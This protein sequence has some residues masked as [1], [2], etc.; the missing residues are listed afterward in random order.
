MEKMLRLCKIQPQEALTE[1]L[2][3]NDKSRIC[4]MLNVV[5]ATYPTSYMR[6]HARRIYEANGEKYAS[7]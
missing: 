1:A 7:I 3:H 2:I 6:D 5:Y 4:D